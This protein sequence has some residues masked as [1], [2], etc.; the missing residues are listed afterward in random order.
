MKIA[1]HLGLAHI[2]GKWRRP[3]SWI[4]YDYY[5]DPDFY[6]D[7][8]K[9]A[10][11]GKIDLV[12]F[13]ENAETPDTYGS[14]FR[15]STTYG[16]SW[17]RH[18]MLPYIPFM[19]AETEHIGF[20]GTVSTT[21]S[22][23]FWVARFFNSLDHVTRG[24][25]G[26]NVVTSARLN[27]A[28]NYG[29]DKLPP[30]TERYARA[31]EFLDVCYGLWNSVPPEAVVLDRGHGI[32]ANPDHIRYLKHEGAH[33]KIKGPLPSIPGPQGRPAICQAGQSPTGMAVAAKYADFQFATRRSLH[34]MIGHRCALDELLRS[35]GRDPGEVCIIWGVNLILDRTVEAARRRYDELIESLSPGTGL[36][37]ISK[38]FAVDVSQFPENATVADIAPAVRA[39]GGMLGFFEELERMA[40][41]HPDFSL[42][43]LGRHASQGST[44]PTL[45]G[46]ATTVADTL[47]HWHRA[48]GGNTGFLIYIDHTQP[49]STIE[50]VDEVVPILQKRGLM[51]NDYDG[52]TLI[53]RLRS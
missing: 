43:E 10:E 23:P 6:A 42:E 9:V 11:R 22:H 50:F 21:Y 28:A 1:L 5:A 33:F 18:D 40:V 41:E 27:E 14:S 7:I 48:I 39:A 16:I 12:F 2:D 25:I 8:A 47:E 34:S 32:V 53:G 4:G 29:F 19:A 26:W 17:P 20:V 37:F 49:A 15:S 24:R 35:G 51:W 36:E 45:I 38:Q 52:S 46:T 13:G 30:P 44:A 31:E 3:G